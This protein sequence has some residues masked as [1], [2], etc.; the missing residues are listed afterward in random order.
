MNKREKQRYDKMVNANYELK[1]GS[2]FLFCPT[3]GADLSLKFIKKN[4][5]F[6]LWSSLFRSRTFSEDELLEIV[7]CVSIR[8]KNSKKPNELGTIERLLETIISGQVVS[9]SLFEKMAKE[10]EKENLRVFKSLVIFFVAHQEVSKEFVIANKNMI[11]LEYINV[12]KN[13]WARIENLPTDIKLL[14]SLGEM[15]VI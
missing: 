10:L 5:F 4:I 9:L 11:R 12:T 13:P 1:K 7:E 15:S 3:V 2:D 14:I 8:L 6:I